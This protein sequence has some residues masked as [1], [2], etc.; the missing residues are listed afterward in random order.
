MEADESTGFFLNGY[1]PYL[2]HHYDKLKFKTR[3]LVF[4]IDKEEYASE[5]KIIREASRLLS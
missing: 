5:L 2:D 1:I 3:V 4:I